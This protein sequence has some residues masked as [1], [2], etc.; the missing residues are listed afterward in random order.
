MSWGPKRSIVLRLDKNN[1]Y[2]ATNKIQPTRSNSVATRHGN[3]VH[4][5][6]DRADSNL[7]EDLGTVSTG[8]L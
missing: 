1:I 2:P 7:Q 8:G 4:R 5:P 3:P 6:S